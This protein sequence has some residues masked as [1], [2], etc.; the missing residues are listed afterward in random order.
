MGNVVQFP[1][2]GKSSSSREMAEEAERAVQYAA[3]CLI[4]VWGPK[5]APNRLEEAAARLREILTP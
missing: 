1:S 3:W 4:Q 2:G 5:V